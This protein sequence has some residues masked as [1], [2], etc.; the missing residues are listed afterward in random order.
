MALPVIREQTRA[1]VSEIEFP[2]SLVVL[3]RF[4]RLNC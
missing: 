3:N 1:D 4:E 2:P